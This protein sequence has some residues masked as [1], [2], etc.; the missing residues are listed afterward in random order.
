MGQMDG[1]THQRSKVRIAQ[2]SDGLSKTYLVGE[3]SVDP[4]LNDLGG[5]AGDD[6]PMLCGDDID[7]NRYTNAPPRQ[8]VIGTEFFHVFGSAHPS[9]FGMALCD[10]SVHSLALDIDPSVHRVLGSRSD[11]SEAGLP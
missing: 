6:Q 3:K 11:G 10:G 7:T 4:S 5:G 8:D 1:I 2:I 9:T